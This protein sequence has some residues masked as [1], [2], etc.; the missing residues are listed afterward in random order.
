MEV[1]K[2]VED[3]A[4]KNG[5]TK[6]QM[7]VLQIGELSPMIPKYVEACYPAAVDGTSLQD[8]ELKIDKNIDQ[9]L[10]TLDATNGSL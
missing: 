2:Q 7:I 8:T 9:I 5:V 6:V 3:F 4:K 1:V 10:N